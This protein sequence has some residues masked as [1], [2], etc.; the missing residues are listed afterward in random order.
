M[1]ARLIAAR[2]VQKVPVAHA[3]LSESRAS[4]V[5]DKKLTRAAPRPGEQRSGAPAP[6]GELSGE[7]DNFGTEE[8]LDQGGLTNPAPE[9]D[10]PARPSPATAGRRRVT[11]Y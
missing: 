9:I 11:S 2:V 4:H 3:S 8:A 5:R 1:M 10:F 7:R 6:R